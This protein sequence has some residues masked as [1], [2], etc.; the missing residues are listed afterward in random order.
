MFTVQLLLAAAAFLLLFTGVAFG[1][2]AGGIFR[3]EN[4]EKGGFSFAEVKLLRAKRSTSA[5]EQPSVKGNGTT[6]G[7]GRLR[8]N[9]GDE[10]GA[11]VMHIAVSGN[12]DQPE[13]VLALLQNGANV[14]ARDKDGRRQLIFLKAGSALSIGLNS[15]FEF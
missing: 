15:F 7:E 14:N 8:V 3:L 6:G 2:G 4:E 10:N 5:G 13:I 12:S 11:T 9:E 1:E